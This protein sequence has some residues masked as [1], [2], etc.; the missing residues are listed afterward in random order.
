M[1]KLNSDLETLRE[2]GYIEGYDISDFKKLDREALLN[3]LEDKQPI[4]RSAAA[5]VI[6]LKYD[7]CNINM[8]N[9]LLKQLSKEK[10]LYTKLEIC[11]TLETGNQITAKEMI[12]YIGKIG[13]NQHKTLP[14]R[15][16]LKQ[17]YPLPRDL[18]A[19][20]LGR[21]R[22]EIMPLLMEVLDSGD[23]IKI[24]EVLD[25]I[26]FL[27]FYDRKAISYKCMNKVIHT[28]E[29]YREDNLILWKGIIC[30]SAFPYPES[31]ECLKNISESAEQPLFREEA[32]R[33]LRVVRKFD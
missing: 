31:I 25:A 14:E 13:K 4:Y 10:K 23:L 27:S 8:A 17:S 2:R 26:G 9:A 28:I 18:I 30:L 7:V 3:L 29:Y 12:S 20:S 24:R 11:S 22:R 33:A 16:T 6:R 15:P 5:K 19:R 1:R 32:K 21:M